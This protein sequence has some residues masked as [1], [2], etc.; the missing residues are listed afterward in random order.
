MNAALGY[1]QRALGQTFCSL[2]QGIGQG[3]GM[4]GIGV[5]GTQAAVVHSHEVG[6]TGDVTEFVR[7]VQFEQYF[8]SQVV[9]F[10]GQRHALRKFQT[11]RDEQYGIGPCGSGLQQLIGINDEILAQNG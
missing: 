5:E 11:G 2:C 3:K 10:F 4:R 1:E 8:Q 9:G 6:G 7:A